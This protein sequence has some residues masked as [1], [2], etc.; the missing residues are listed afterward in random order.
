MITAYKFEA[1]DLVDHEPYGGRTPYKGRGTVVGNVRHLSM[2]LVEVR[3]DSGSVTKQGRL[4]L[5]LLRA[6]PKPQDQSLRF[7]AGDDVK[8]YNNAATQR[9]KVVQDCRL[10]DLNVFL[11]LHSESVCRWVYHKSVSKEPFVVIDEAGP[12][13]Q[14]PWT[15]AGWPKIGMD[16]ARGPDKTS[17][18]FRMNPKLRKWE[19]SYTKG[20]TEELDR[21][22]RMTK[23]P[24]AGLG[25]QNAITLLRGYWQDL[26]IPYEQRDAALAEAKRMD[27]VC[28]RFRRELSEQDLVKEDLRNK[29][30]AERLENVKLRETIANGQRA[31][32]HKA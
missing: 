25:L 28:T 21:L 20:V 4:T 6:A 19:T 22:R 15:T 2:N 29:L 14:N 27:E 16:W 30:A 13:P 12:V 9:G 7:K 3:W 26:H 23:S 11:K 24:M 10:T 32:E 1:G 8:F 18:H 17:M 5:R 31:L